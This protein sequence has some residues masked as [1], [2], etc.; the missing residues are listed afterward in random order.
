MT[1]QL[2]RQRL[3]AAWARL[4]AL[5]VG[6]DAFEVECAYAELTEARRELQRFLMHGNRKQR[7]GSE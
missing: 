4:Q 7:A 5:R 2:A 1:R 3:A 6:G